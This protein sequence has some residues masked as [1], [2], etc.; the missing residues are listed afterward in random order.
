MPR[1]S[2]PRQPLS[3]PEPSRCTRQAIATGLPILLSLILL[4]AIAF[5][6]PPDP[7]WVAG[8]YD[9]ADGDDI[10]CLIYETSATSVI[11][12]S[13]LGP[14]PCLL[15]IPLESIA[16]NVPGR[17]YTRG[18]RSP[19]V[20]RSPEFGHVFNSLPPPTSGA[21]A[22]VAFQTLVKLRPS[23]NGDLRALRVA[24]ELAPVQDLRTSILAERSVSRN[25]PRAPPAAQPFRLTVLAAAASA[26]ITEPTVFATEKSRTLPKDHDGWVGG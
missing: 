1:G 6:S 5:A 18:P 20:L 12:P 7:S 24:V 15:E 26:V 10:V 22:P 9:G 8:F 11:A 21:E 4:P 23:W 25:Q 3:P 14:L 13:H 16:R 2:C 17:H 19:P